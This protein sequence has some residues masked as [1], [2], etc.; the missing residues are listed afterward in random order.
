MRPTNP[1][2]RYRVAPKWLQENLACVKAGRGP[3]RLCWWRG[4]V[5]YVVN[6]ET[7]RYR[8]LSD[9]SNILLDEEKIPIHTSLRCKR[10]GIR[11]RITIHY[12]ASDGYK[13]VLKIDEELNIK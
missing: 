1:I 10:N 5:T 9:Y 7:Q 6:V 11:G 8:K 13:G 12:T 3:L 4:T 2:H